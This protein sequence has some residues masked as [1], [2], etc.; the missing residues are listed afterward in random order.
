VNEIS[1]AI[2]QARY[3]NKVFWR[4][5][6]AAFFT[7]AF[8][9]MFLVIF[10]LVFGGDTVKGGITASTFYV[11]ALTAFAIITACYTNLAMNVSIARDQGRLKRIRGTPL[12]TW[13]YLFGK[14][15]N[16]L[17]V[18]AVLVALMLLL[19]VAAY[20]AQT[21]G[22]NWG[23]FVVS[24]AV[25]AVCFCSLGMAI[26]PFIP[27]EDAAPAVVNA[28][29]LPLL[30]ISDVF[31]PLSNA[32]GW[33]TTLSGIFPPIHFAH[34]L[35]HSFIADPTQPFDWWDVIVMAIWTAAGVAVALTRFS[36]EP[37]R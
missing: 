11:P 24:L 28:S 19:G 5:P 9:L 34:S 14:I 20:G 1:L 12:P 15:A 25:G 8:P 37:R 7:F 36:W 31:I 30:F 18:A 16:A 6:P 26:V 17:I 10:N 27:N 23:Q 22:A 13:A 32:P 4:N 33:L 2:G 35:L 3:E 29:V 21:S